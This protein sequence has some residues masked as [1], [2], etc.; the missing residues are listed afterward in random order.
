MLTETEFII[1]CRHLNLSEQARKKVQHIRSSQPS[2]RVRAGSRHVLVAIPVG[3][4]CL[5]EASPSLE[6]ERSRGDNQNLALKQ[7]VV[8]PQYSSSEYSN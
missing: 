6:S 8:L 4:T 7:I 1:W 2:H 5:R 3:G